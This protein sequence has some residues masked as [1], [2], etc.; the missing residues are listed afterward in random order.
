MHAKAIQHKKLSCNLSF[1]KQLTRVLYHASLNSVL[2]SNIRRCDMNLLLV[3]FTSSLF[4][5]I[6]LVV[7]QN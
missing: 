7:K 2:L 5:I 3:Q 4:R 1:L 6:F